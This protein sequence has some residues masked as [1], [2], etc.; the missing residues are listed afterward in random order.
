MK[1]LGM[2]IISGNKADKFTEE[3]R[4]RVTSDIFIKRFTYFF[5]VI[6]TKDNLRY[7]RLVL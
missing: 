1:A 5:W 3:L 4:N 2:S 7:I 6:I